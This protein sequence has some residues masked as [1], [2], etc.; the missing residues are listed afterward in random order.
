MKTQT[1]FFNYRLTF[2][3]FFTAIT[4][5]VL[6]LRAIHFIESFFVENP[7]WYD[8]AVAQG[9]P[10]QSPPSTNKK[11]KPLSPAKTPTP[12]TPGQNT[13]FQQPQKDL[14]IGHPD[15]S[16]SNNQINTQIDPL[17]MSEAEAGVLLD[18]VKRRQAL[19]LKEKHVAAEE[20]KATQVSKKLQG[21]LQQL[22][23]LWNKVNATSKKFFHKKNKNVVQ[24]EQDLAKIY[25]NMDPIKA[26]KIFNDMSL[27]VAVPIF[28]V[29]ERKKA[30][31]IFQNMDPGKVQEITTVLSEEPEH[32][33]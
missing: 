14:T 12:A 33:G 24:M 9:P 17:N 8:E 22:Q 1:G 28:K 5:F 25:A 2:L 30:S 31:A 3:T 10:T 26:A 23:D 4:L 18:M 16:N 7:E 19:A 6:G 27:E 20:E 29:M 11:S 21:Y 13:N 32:I 15:D